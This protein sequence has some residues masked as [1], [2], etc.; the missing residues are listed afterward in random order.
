MARCL[1]ELDHAVRWNGTSRCPENR[2]RQI[3]CW[4]LCAVCWVSVHRHRRAHVRSGLSSFTSQVSLGPASMMGSSKNGQ[5]F[6]GGTCQI[7]E[8]I[9]VFVSRDSDDL[10][11]LP[12]YNV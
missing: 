7:R 2:W 6:K 9:R 1:F 11:H 3:V 4:V 8:A 5:G 10:I 12:C